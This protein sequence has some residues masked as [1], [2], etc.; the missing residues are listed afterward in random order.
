[1][2]IS[3]SERRM[4]G[5]GGAIAVGII[6]YS[7]WPSGSTVNTAGM[8]ATQD[9]K[10]KKNVALAA[11]KKLKLESEGYQPQIAAMSYDVAPDELVPLMVRELQQI[12]AKSGVHL[13]E[14]KPVRPHLLTSGMGSSVPLEVHFLAP[15]Q[16][17]TMKFLYQVEDPNGKLV[18]DK[19]DITSA[20]P[21]RK[22]VEVSVTV[23][24]YTRKLAGASGTEGGDTNNATPA[25]N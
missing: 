9:A 5:F 22:T 24:G 15:F 25:K 18:V 12:A 13:R 11:L 20:D 21:R 8:L 17:N 6:L 16:P 1:M 10:S 23:T 19:L 2:A 14:Y 3:P 7:L 4:I